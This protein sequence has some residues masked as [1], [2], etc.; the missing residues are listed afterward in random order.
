MPDRGPQRLDSVV[1][2]ITTSA[3]ALSLV[4]A[5]IYLSITLSPH[6]DLTSLQAV[7]VGWAGIVVGFYFGGHV[8]QNTAAL[9][10][11]RMI[12]AAD[13]S[14]ASAVRSEASAVRSERGE[15]S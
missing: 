2:T 3:L 6:R 4:G 14:E 7:L 8:A 13:I 9:E 5:I 12:K 11:A 1:R 15:V 10:E